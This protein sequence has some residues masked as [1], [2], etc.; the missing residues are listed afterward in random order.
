MNLIFVVGAARSG[1]S[2]LTQLIERMGARTLPKTVTGSYNPDYCENYVLNALCYGIHPWHKLAEK[3]PDTGTNIKAIASYIHENIGRMNHEYNIGNPMAKPVTHLVL[4]CPAFPFIIPELK[5]AVALL[6]DWMAGGVDAHWVT[7][8]RDQSAQIASLQN[9]TMHTWTDTHWKLVLYKA[10]TNMLSFVT[11]GRVC[12]DV[13]YEALINDWRAVAL[14]LEHKIP[15]LTVPADGG[16]R[17]ELNHAEA[18]HA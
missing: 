15:G 7:I 17:P 2:A 16:I 12:A 10:S 11:R 4:K 1:T 18:L 5:E 14:K 6:D 3:G 13:M 9:F 8:D